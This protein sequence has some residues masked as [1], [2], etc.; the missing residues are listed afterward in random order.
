MNGE[1]N[2]A[3]SEESSPE[4]NPIED[5]LS[6]VLILLERVYG[7]NN[8]TTREYLL[9]H[10]LTKEVIEVNIERCDHVHALEEAICTNCK[11]K[12]LTDI[13]DKWVLRVVGF[14]DIDSRPISKHALVKNDEALSSYIKIM[15]EK[16]NL[17]D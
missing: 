16:F 17:G 11:I 2:P 4:A 14:S 15:R 12:A 5:M 8:L 10:L 13:A 6:D 7:I 3:R 9:L 1:P